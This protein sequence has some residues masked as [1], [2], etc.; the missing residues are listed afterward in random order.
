[1]SGT[2]TAVSRG[3]RDGDALVERHAPL[4]KRIA[5]HLSGRL[6]PSVQVDD[7][8]QAGMLGLL[9]AARHYDK[10]GLLG[11][12]SRRVNCMLL[13]PRNSLSPRLPTTSS[14]APIS[15]NPS[16]KGPGRQPKQIA[17]SSPRP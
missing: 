12:A 1:M 8:M 17:S 6:P 9:D 15:N 3:M 5:Y 14:R 7:L 13:R 16:P 10:S 2:A 11:R 4:V